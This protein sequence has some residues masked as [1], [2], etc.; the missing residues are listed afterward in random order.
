MEQGDR[1]LAWEKQLASRLDEAPSL[2]GPSLSALSHGLGQM[3]SLGASGS[4]GNM[5]SCACKAT[6]AL[7]CD[8]VCHCTE[9]KTT[10]GLQGA[11]S[12]SP[13]LSFQRQ[14][15][16]VFQLHTL[17]NPHTVRTKA[18]T[19]QVSTERLLFAVPTASRTMGTQEHQ[20]E[21]CTHS[22]DD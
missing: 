5:D 7:L 18:R 15:P 1:L 17:R 11:A 2:F 21:L 10:C 14:M 16:G 22:T 8:C 19:P 12:V 3:A 13:L 6:C 4:L 9:C 20:F